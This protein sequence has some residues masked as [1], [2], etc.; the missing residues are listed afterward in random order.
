MPTTL[1]PTSPAN[2]P[3][4]FSAPADGDAANVASVNTIL[5]A[6]L[7]GET[8]LRMALYGGGGVSRPAT[9]SYNGTSVVVGALAGMILTE[10]GVWTGR[11]AVAGATFTVADLEGGGS[12]SAD[13][14]YYMYY[15][16]SGGSVTRAIS[17]TGPDTTRRYKSATTTHAY[18]GCFR[19]DGSVLI[20]PYHAVRGVYHF[21]DGAAPSANPSGMGP[22]DISLVKG[23]PPTSRIA[24]LLLVGY[25]TS[26]TN[27]VAL[28]FY[29]KGYGGT[30]G[31]PGILNARVTDASSAGA[32]TY[33]TLSFPMG[34][35]GSQ[36]V[37]FAATATTYSA[38]LTIRG[39]EED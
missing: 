27:L 18:L 13:T 35:D 6:T 39:F 23:V 8:A 31:F 15:Y 19:V 21:V 12:F 32:N 38:T 4:S 9:Y 34:T 29:P 28:N 16:L 3:A 2:I 11:A 24:H 10:S 26:D 25:S 20:E 37:T 22:T 30:S 33:T 17:A 14:W 36:N 7:D 1:T 5:Q